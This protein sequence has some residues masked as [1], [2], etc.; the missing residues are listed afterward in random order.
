MEVKFDRFYRF[1]EFSEI[2]QWYAATYPEILSIESIG[3]SFE[4]RD[5]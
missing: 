2:L 3:K 1:A 4:G 5:I